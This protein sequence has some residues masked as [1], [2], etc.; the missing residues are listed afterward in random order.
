MFMFVFKEVEI[1][2]AM[3]GGRLWDMSQ[4]KNSWSSGSSQP[5]LL[6]GCRS[7]LLMLLCLVGGKRNRKKVTTF[8]NMKETGFWF[9]SKSDTSRFSKEVLQQYTV[10]GI[11]VK[12]AQQCEGYGKSILPWNVAVA[13]CYSNCFVCR[14]S[15]SNHWLSRWAWKRP[16]LTGSGF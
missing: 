16:Y 14:R 2:Q 5:S 12:L 8:D 15:Q 10:R 6:Q 11:G 1:F 13:Q 3:F 4:R 7:F 9:V